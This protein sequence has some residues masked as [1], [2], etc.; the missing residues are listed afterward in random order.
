MRNR[1]IGVTLLA[2]LGLA[3]S[4]Q[5]YS[6]EIADDDEVLRIQN[7][8]RR[9]LI[10]IKDK[11]TDLAK[12]VLR[13]QDEI[14]QLKR[15]LVAIKARFPKQHSCPPHWTSFGTS[16]YLVVKEKKMHEDAAM[17]CIRYGSKLVEIETAEENEF[18]RNNLLRTSDD[19]PKFWTGGT[20]ADVE[21]NWIWSMTGKPFTTFES[22][23]TGEPNNDDYRGKEEHCL[24]FIRTLSKPW[25]DSVC[26]L[27]K[28]FICEKNA[29][30]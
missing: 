16:C 22:W 2:A 18:I 29:F 26:N 25:N 27:T 21:G 7:Q 1:Y 13:N 28:P 15:E 24:E 17:H 3:V 8:L 4:Q 20:D 23:K 12:T 10:A 5:L 6:R 14:Y 30:Y 9:E 11:E 19:N